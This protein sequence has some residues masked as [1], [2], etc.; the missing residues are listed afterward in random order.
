M[1]KLKIF[2]IL[3]AILAVLSLSLGGCPTQDTSAPEPAPAP[4]PTPTPT[5]T[6]GTLTIYN[7]STV[8]NDSISKV[9]IW[10]PNAT[11]AT[12]RYTVPIAR[13]ADHSFTL[14]AGGYEVRVW[15][16]Y[17]PNATNPPYRT[18]IS[19]T[20]GGSVNVK[21]NGSSLSQ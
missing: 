15:D 7:I 11:T 4:A 16:N 20:V 19:I 13:N 10:A 14:Q 6:T 2:A 9:E 5:P 21:Y 18:N 12:E 1:K 3:L 8:T 17:T